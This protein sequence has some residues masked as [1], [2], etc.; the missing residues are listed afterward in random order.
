MIRLPSPLSRVGF[1]SGGEGR[2]SARALPFTA[3]VA[4]ARPPEAVLVPWNGRLFDPASGRSEALADTSPEALAVAARKLLS[5]D[6]PRV[7]LALP[8]REFFALTLN[9]P[10]LSAEQLHD[11]IQLQLGELLPGVEQPMALRVVT[12]DQGG[13]VLAL[14]LPVERGEALF[15]AF[16][17]HGLFLSVIV[18]RPAL[19]PPREGVWSSERE[20]GF[21]TCVRWRDGRI[22]EWLSTAEADLELEALAE[23]LREALGGEQP[24]TREEEAAWSAAAPSSE[25]PEPAFVPEGA[26]LRILGAQR[27]RRRRRQLIAASVVFGVMVAFWGLLAG[28]MAY[29]ERKLDRLMVAAEEASQLRGKAVE[30]ESRMAPLFDFPTQD[31]AGV[32][33]VLN[34]RIPRDSWIE[35]LQIDEGVV[36]LEGYSPDPAKLVALLDED[37]RFEEVAFSRATRGDGRQ[38]ERFGIRFRLVGIDV[39]AYL[40][41]HFPLARR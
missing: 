33:E 35:R 30:V 25:W 31:V 16:G 37:E 11:A 15:R 34:R 6:R 38:G 26:R 5:S 8:G 28:R 41:E 1:R 23:Q 22:T 29:F 17:N 12:P 32:L 4:E 39:Q 24:E 19:A 14:W 21:V 13:A 40:Q 10:G 7:A 36:E 3:P 9:L 27:R 2:S 20:G 18:P